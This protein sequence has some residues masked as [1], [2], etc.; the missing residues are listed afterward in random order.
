VFAEVAF[1][2]KRMRC[3]AEEVRQR[4][5]E[6][7]SLCGAEHLVSRSPLTLSFGEQHRVS[8]AS[9]LAPQPELLLLDEPFA[10]LDFPQ[11]YKI[12]EIL[13]E[14]RARRGTTVVIVSHGELPDP[15]WADRVITL[16][17]GTI[18]YH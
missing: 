17:H 18:T 3:D 5:M 16:E 14:L 12:L 4:A 2:L 15:H 8:L 13:S 10:G 9:I 6:T 7:L 11:R 1:S